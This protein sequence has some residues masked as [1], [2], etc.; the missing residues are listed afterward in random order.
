MSRT[1]KEDEPMREE[2][3]ARF[4]A[5]QKARVRHAAAKRGKTASDFIREAVLDLT[6][7]VLAEDPL[8]PYRGFIGQLDVPGAWGRNH[9]DAYTAALMQK[10][11][12]EKR[13]T[14]KATESEHEQA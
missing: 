8:A 3:S 12:P 1:T 6:E 10:Y 2:L 11:A 5:A 7:R 14:L 9:K 13:R 4:T